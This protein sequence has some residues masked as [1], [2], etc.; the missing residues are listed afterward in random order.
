VI[1]AAST[2]ISYYFI[3]KLLPPVREE[4]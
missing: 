3:N 1:F 4:T 2:S